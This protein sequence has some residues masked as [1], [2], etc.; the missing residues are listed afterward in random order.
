MRLLHFHRRSFVIRNQ[1]EAFDSADDGSRVR[2]DSSRLDYML[3]KQLGHASVSFRWRDSQYGQR[4]TCSLEGGVVG[5]IAG[6]VWI[7]RSEVQTGNFKSLERSS[8]VLLSIHAVATSTRFLPS[9]CSG[10]NPGSV[11]VPDSQG[12]PPRPAMWKPEV[13]FRP[14]R[15]ILHRPAGNAEPEALCRWSRHLQDDRKID[16]AFL[17]ESAPGTT[18]AVKLPV[19]VSV[20]RLPRS[21]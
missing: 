15:S 17:V 9:S 18:A 21:L 2:V 7:A 1:S 19:S 5:T 10:R 20:Q 4:C 12:R 3:L 8:H 16:I 11:S 6:I 13:P 14:A